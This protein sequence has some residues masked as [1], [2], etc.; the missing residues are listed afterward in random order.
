MLCKK[1]YRSFARS[2]TDKTDFYLLGKFWWNQQSACCLRENQRQWE[3]LLE[4]N[5]CWCWSGMMRWSFKSKYALLNLLIDTAPVCL[6]LHILWQCHLAIF[7]F[8]RKQQFIN[9]SIVTSQAHMVLHFTNTVRPSTCLQF[10]TDPREK[11]KHPALNICA[12]E[13]SQF[14]TNWGSELP[15]LFHQEPLSFQK[16]KTNQLVQTA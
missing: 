16:L 8:L 6:H 10:Q 2:K 5:S 1:M 3:C 13:G 11:E 7:C 14:M 12:F 4:V 9:L 15:P